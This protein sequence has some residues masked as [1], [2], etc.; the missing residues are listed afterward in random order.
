MR[1]RV[2]DFLFNPFERIAGWQALSWGLAGLLI[3]TA[4]GYITNYHYHGLLHYG[5]APNPA[6]WCFAAE[7]IIVWLI[8]TL[9]FYI[10]GLILS[11]SKIRPVDVFGTVLFSQIPLLFTNLMAF[12]PFYKQMESFDPNAPVAEQIQQATALITQPGFWVG[13]W[14]SLLS[15]AFVIWMGYWMYRALAVSCNLKGKRLALLFLVSLFGG[16]FICRLI[17]NLLY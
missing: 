8:P 17:I 4:L 9:I 15:M 14:L 12:F 5:P 11:K 1:K 16:D 7:R 3:S 10:G 6:W 2:I 13:I